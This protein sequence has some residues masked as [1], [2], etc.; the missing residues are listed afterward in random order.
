ME[1]SDRSS[2]SPAG[3]VRARPAPWRAFSARWRRLGKWPRRAAAAVL[4][5][6]IALVA[7]EVSGWPF[8]RAPL[9]ARLSSALKREVR[10]EGDFRMRLLGSV[11]L[12]TQR[13]TIGPPAWAGEQR[14]KFV[15][16]EHVRLV[17]PY[18][19]VLAALRGGSHEPLRVRALEVGRFDAELWRD[20]EGRANWQFREEPPPPS[21]EDASVPVFDRLVVGNGQ[22]A[23][24]DAMRGLRVSARARTEE[25]ARAEDAAGLVVEGQGRF[26]DADFEFHAASRGVMPLIASEGAATPVPLALRASTGRT[27]LAFEGQAV[28]I[29]R[30]HGFD[31]R[32]QASGPSLAAV[33]TPFGLTLPSTPEFELDGRLRKEGEVWK[34]DVARLH[35]GSSRLAGRFTYDRRP[36]RPLLTGSLEG[37]R[38][39][40]RDLGPAFGAP[41]GPRG[42]A[43]P[44]AASDDGQILPE[45]EFNL[46]S[47]RRMDADV[48]VNLRQLDLGT[49]YL[50]DLKPLEGHVRLQDGV[51]RI[52]DL[53]ASASGGRVTGAIGLD[54]RKRTPNWDIDLRWAGV[55]LEQWLKVRNPR[56]K[57]GDGSPAPYIS[58][59]LG[60]QA[61]FVGAGRSTADMLGSL[62]GGTT[63]WIQ[64]GELS[65]LVIEALGIDIAESLGIL[66]RGD[67]SLPVRCAVAQF[68]ARDGHLKT[69]VGLIDTPD[70]TL[71]VEGT[72]SLRQERLALQVKAR[73]KDFTPLSLRAPIRIEGSFA[74]PAIRPEGKTLGLKLLGAAALAA[75]T[76]LAAIIPL[77]DPGE[78]TP[79]GC[80]LAL[81][82]LRG[83][84]ARR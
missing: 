64:N 63:L 68:T 2:T 50:G 48:R 62:D 69:E 70:T 57:R 1:P 23:Y 19:T 41:A 51:L 59:V 4:A 36:E 22:I 30:L 32:F 55:R 45:R 10:L 56:D 82:R 66:V 9:E 13:L 54:G 52:S 80:H 61:K 81:E 21:R 65:H 25:G 34:A 15:S 83:A 26:R 3:P 24:D 60:G 42:G 28:D 71:L 39:V 11:R 35:V 73:P 40:L 16:G 46:P 18:S 74:D 75:V 37:E 76:P 14:P 47:L 20:A 8:L 5:V 29:L 31:G 44:R 84:P 67:E 43:S 58:G 27:R 77:I 38:L 78:R 6:L 72:V 12:A 17:L 79:G 53:V 7:G 49:P 33:G